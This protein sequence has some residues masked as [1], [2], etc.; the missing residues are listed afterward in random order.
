MKDEH[1]FNNS[2]FKI[3]SGSGVEIPK[4]TNNKPNG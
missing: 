1:N 3:N 4:K 2:I